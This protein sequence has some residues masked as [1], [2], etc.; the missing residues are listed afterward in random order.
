MSNHAS[1]SLGRSSGSNS[2]SQSKRYPVSRSPAC[3]INPTR[4][5]R[6]FE[7]SVANEM[8]C[9]L[10]LCSLVLG[11]RFKGQRPKTQDQ[12]LHTTPLDHEHRSPAS[13]QYLP[14]VMG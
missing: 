6:Q 3:K 5:K 11:L 14:C 13:V 4:G 9:I 1:G 7:S 2:F 8:M 12:L 10:R